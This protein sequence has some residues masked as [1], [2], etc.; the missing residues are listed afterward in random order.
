[1]IILNTHCNSLPLHETI[2]PYEKSETEI[3]R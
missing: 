1:M 2:Q 3:G